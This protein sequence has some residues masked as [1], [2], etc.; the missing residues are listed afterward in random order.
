VLATPGGPADCLGVTST[1]RSEDDAWK[2]VHRHADPITK[3]DA[4]GP[5][6][7][8]FQVH[9]N[10]RA[11]GDVAGERGDRAAG[12]RTVERALPERRDDSRVPS[13]S[14]ISTWTR[15][16][17]CSIRLCITDVTACVAR[18]GTSWRHGPQSRGAGEAGDGQGQRRDPSATVQNVGTGTSTGHGAAL[19]AHAESCAASVPVVP[20]AR[21]RR[22]RGCQT[23]QVLG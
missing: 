11:V 21:R 13:A 23:S 10:S 9:R 17:V 6:R 1:Y 7:S 20:S 22:A 4:D 14:P 2:L 19:A 15:H 18:S 3:L 5:T 12:G 8:R 16:G